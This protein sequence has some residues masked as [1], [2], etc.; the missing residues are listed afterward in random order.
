[1]MNGRPQMCLYCS[2]L[3]HV[4]RR[5]W[6][7]PTYA[8]AAAVVEKMNP[9]VPDQ[10]PADNDDLETISNTSNATNEPANMNDMDLDLEGE[11]RAGD[12][13]TV[14]QTPDSQENLRPGGS[15]SAAVAS[16]PLFADQS[17]IPSGT[18]RHE[19]LIAGTQL[20]AVSPAPTA[21]QR[22]P[23]AQKPVPQM[24]PRIE[25]EIADR[26]SKQK[27]QQQQQLE[28]QR[29]QQQQ[30]KMGPPTEPKPAAKPQQQPP[31]Q[32]QP[33]QPQNR[34][35][36]RHRSSTRESSSRESENRERDHSVGESDKPVIRKK[37]TIV[38]KNTQLTR[39]Q[40]INEFASSE[41]M[42]VSHGSDNLD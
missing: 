33:P 13:T 38:V 30:Q 41:Q 21:A 6:E 32:P 24:D 5:R 16:Q 37:Q 17:Q 35:S 25:S 10:M 31:K 7:R 3:G 15:G 34:Q 2:E 28:Q 4:R 8:A 1:M 9:I 40:M 42:D 26:A 27:Q 39:Q 23:I 18:S 12:T 20:S 14:S 19:V 29:Q 36:H 11:E 22:Q